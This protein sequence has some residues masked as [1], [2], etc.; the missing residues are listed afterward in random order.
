MAVVYWQVRLE[1]SYVLCVCFRK[2]IPARCW[3]SG[4][5]AN[6]EPRVGLVTR[7]TQRGFICGGLG[8]QLD[9]GK[10]IWMLYLRHFGIHVALFWLGA[11]YL[12]LGAL[13]GSTQTGVI[14]TYT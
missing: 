12:G 7:P 8:W 1:A 13:Q 6:T 4:I 2:Y 10:S 5:R 14:V 11:G 9:L 3:V